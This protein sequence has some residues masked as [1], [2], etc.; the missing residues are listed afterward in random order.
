MQL[1]AGHTARTSPRS[2]QW[3]TANFLSKNEVSSKFNT[4]TSAPWPTFVNFGAHCDDMG[5]RDGDG[6]TSSAGREVAAEAENSSLFP[7]LP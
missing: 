7:V 1:H 5:T 2:A 3:L 4:Q 6:V